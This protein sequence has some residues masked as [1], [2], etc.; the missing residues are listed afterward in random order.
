MRRYQP[1]RT[2]PRQPAPLHQVIAIGPID[3]A[4]GIPEFSDYDKLPPNRRADRP[5][6]ILGGILKDSYASTE[7]G[8]ATAAY[9]GD[10][11]DSDAL[12]GWF[13]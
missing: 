12:A 3:R 9:P 13:A 8:V 10:V 11:N 2:D 7:S 5:R 4:P 6:G 1:G